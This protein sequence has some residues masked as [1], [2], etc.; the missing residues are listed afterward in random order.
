M[1]DTE[2]RLPTGARVPSDAEDLDALP[3]PALL[4]DETVL[5][6]NLARMAEKAR[7][8]GVSLRP[9]VKTHKCPPIAALQ[10]ER[11]ATGITVST[12]AEARAFA[13]AGFHDQTWAFPLPLSR[14]D[15]ALELTGRIDLGLTVDSVEALD[16]LT[17]R[18]ARARVWLKVDCGY[19]RAGVD[20]TSEAATKLAGRVHETPGLRFAGIL[21]HSGHAYGVDSPMEAAAVAEEERGVM[22]G[23]ADRLRRSGIPVPGVSVGS[24]PSMAQARDLTGV[25]E[26]RPGNYAF[27]DYTQVALGSCAVKDVAVTVLATVISRGRDH[28]VVDAGA[29]A[30]SKDLGPDERPR[31]YGRL[32]RGLDEPALDP[33]LRVLSVS[34]EHGILNAP[35]SVGTRVRILPN[36]SCL[37]V[38]N[39]DRY[40]VLREGRPAESWRIR[41]DR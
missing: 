31:G 16:A 12:L 9:H 25:T 19:G 24:T 32:W 18:G 20:P 40:V 41:R 26:A 27:Y 7:S 39:F 29:L 38:W 13:E 35:L 22:A 23:L 14:V 34:Q 33:E 37:A 30:L 28:S 21:S 36:H 8:L 17:A 6:R 11:G 15:E 1:T 4:L 3:T 10:R 2:S 5:E